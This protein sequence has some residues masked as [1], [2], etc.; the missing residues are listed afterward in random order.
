MEQGDLEHA[1]CLNAHFRGGLPVD[2]E[3]PGRRAVIAAEVHGEMSVDEDPRVVVAIELDV[4]G[5]SFIEV[6]APCPTLYQRRNKLGDGVAMVQ[7]F[8]EKST[9][10]DGA[11]T[12]DVGLEFQGD[13]IVGDFVERERTTFQDNYKA[14]MT[15]VLGDAFVPYEGAK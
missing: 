1:V 4:I 5:F 9:V 11:D 6:L 7:Y 2:L 10:Q 8:K 14:R 15:E 13:I 3:A 12:K